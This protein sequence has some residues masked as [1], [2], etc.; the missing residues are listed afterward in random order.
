MT[1]F[2]VN[3]KTLPKD[4][5][6]K[7]QRPLSTPNH[8]NY[9]IKHLFQKPNLRWKTIIITFLWFTNTSVYVGLSYY[10]PALGDF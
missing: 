9:G 8:T 4:V 7:L 3:G 1:T 5:F 10:A 2:R 6:A